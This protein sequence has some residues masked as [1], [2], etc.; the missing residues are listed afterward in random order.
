MSG[1]S[2]CREQP[3]IMPCFSAKALSCAQPWS[4]TIWTFPIESCGKGSAGGGCKETPEPKCLAAVQVQ[5]SA[6]WWGTA[7]GAG[8]LGQS[9]HPVCNA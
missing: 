6:L 5:R 7:G 1:H 3:I 4:A 9:L 8:S 2:S